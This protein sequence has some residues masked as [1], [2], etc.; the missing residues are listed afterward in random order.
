MLVETDVFLCVLERFLNRGRTVTLPVAG[1]SMQ[2]W[3][4]DKTDRVALQKKDQYRIGDI[5]LVKNGASPYLLHRILKKRDGKYLIGGDSNLFTDG[6]FE[7][8][9]ILAAVTAVERDHSGQWTKTGVWYQKMK[10]KVWYHMI[11]VRHSGYTT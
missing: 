7:P 5:V 10:Y 4:Q 11:K 6:W 3:L 1:N 2:P 9:M 8:E